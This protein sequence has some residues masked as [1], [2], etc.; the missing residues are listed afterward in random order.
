MFTEL[1]N[2]LGTDLKKYVMKGEVFRGPASKEWSLE[3][4]QEFL[5]EF[6]SFTIV[7]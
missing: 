2:K 1:L 3:Q 4:I 5:E 6:T 7:R